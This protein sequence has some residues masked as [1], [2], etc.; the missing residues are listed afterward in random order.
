MRKTLM[1]LNALYMT[2]MVHSANLELDQSFHAGST[3][4]WKKDFEGDSY[5]YWADELDE[6]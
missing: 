3:A 1:M 4:R 5:Q 6:L 2:N